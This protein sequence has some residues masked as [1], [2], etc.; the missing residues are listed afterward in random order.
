[1][2]PYKS[3]NVADP[4]AL[5]VRDGGGS[6]D[7]LESAVSAAAVIGLA[8]TVLVTFYGQTRIFMRMSSDGMLPDRLGRVSERFETPTAA[9]VVCA[10][11]GAAVAAL[12]PI[13]IL[14]D[15]VSIGTLLSFTIV[16]AGVLV[17]RRQPSRPR[18]PVPRQGRLAR[19]AARDR[20]RGRA[21]GDAADHDLDPPRR[22]AARS[23]C[24]IYFVYARRRTGER[25]GRLA[26]TEEADPGPVT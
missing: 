9:T 22:L 26:A 18:A 20:L 8:A 3:L 13:D 2:V 7:W 12:L 10:V 15:L 21:D 5:A 4:L 11:A 6:L 1:M 19:G 16:C 23:A 25:M 17:L 24:V 14:G